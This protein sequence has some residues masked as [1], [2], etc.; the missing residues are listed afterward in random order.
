MV[1]VAGCESMRT[2]V[3]RGDEV[4]Q[5]AWALLLKASQLDAEDLASE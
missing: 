5:S 2:Q 4:C 3:K 1:K